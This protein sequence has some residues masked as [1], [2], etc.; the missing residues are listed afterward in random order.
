MTPSEGE[1]EQ[2]MEE[3]SVAVEVDLEDDTQETPDQ[4]RLDDL[5]E[6]VADRGGVPLAAPDS[7]R[8]GARFC[9]TTDD[10]AAAVEEGVGTFKEAAA[11]AG[12]PDNPIV[13]AEAKTLSELAQEH[14]GPEVP[15]LIDLAG[16]AELLGVSPDLGAIVIRFRDFP[17]PAAELSGGPVWTRESIDRFLRRTQVAPP[18]AGDDVP[19]RAREALSPEED[20]QVN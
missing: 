10:P 19:E 2:S 5:R 9:V 6:A 17:A 16:L 1:R 15:D 3:R 18:P 12:V 4:G 8:Y 13:E 7:P 14:E 11:S 20:S